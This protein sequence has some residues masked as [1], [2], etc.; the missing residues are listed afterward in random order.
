MVDYVKFTVQAG[1]G[2]SGRVSFLRDKM[3]PKG[4]PDGGWGG[5]GGNVWVV[6][7]SQVAT[8][9]HLSGVKQVVALP[10]SPG[11]SQ[12]Q[13]GKKGE[14]QTITVPVGTLIWVSAQNPVAN[15]RQWKYQD[16]IIP[17]DQQHLKQYHLIKPGGPPPPDDQ[18]ERYELLPVLTPDNAQ[19]QAELK[20][21]R[22]SAYGV[23]LTELTTDGQR[24]LLCQGGYGGRGNTAF[25]GPA[26]QTPLMAEWGGPA[27]MKEV[28]FELKL[29]ADVAFVGFPSVGK[30]TLLSALTPARPKIASYPFT[31]L[32]P[33]LGVLRHDNKEWI[34]ADIPGIIEDAHIGKGLGIQFLRHLDR[35]AGLCYVLSPE[36]FEIIEQPKVDHLVDVIATQLQLLQKELSYHDPALVAKPYLVVIS[37]ADLY[38]EPLRQDIVRA[39]PAKKIQAIFV[40]APLHEGTDELIK[41]LISF[42]PR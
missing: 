23:Y 28:S 13:R 1:E 22:T 34:L 11:G 4:G 9:Q 5:D 14:D 25:K 12:N 36:E 10:G 41:K 31:T 37:K 16:Q 27:E 32:E 29:L 3:S 40:S 30:S 6:A 8:L 7:S 2:G 24:Y 15:F 19:A 26:M 18:A 21:R 38:P 17:R 33:Q 35:C 20:N 39:L 42:S